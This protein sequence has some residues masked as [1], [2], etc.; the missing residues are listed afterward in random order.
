M[1]RTLLRVVLL[2][3]VVAA[4]AAFFIG[5]RFAD[6][7]RADQPEHA[8]GT[9]GGTVDVDRAR[10]AGARIGKTVAAGA[11]RAQRVAS[12]AAL[13]A[14]INPRWRRTTRSRLPASTSIRPT[15]LSRCE[16]RWTPSSANARCGW[17]AK[18]T[19]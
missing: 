14:K 18:P 3:I 6:R 2:L 8:V 1:V 11:N 16:A 5:C 19:V 15:A 12:D 7:D 10:E 13:T 17:R 9:T 4:I